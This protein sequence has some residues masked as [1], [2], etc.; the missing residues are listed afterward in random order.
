MEILILGIATAFNFI[1]IKWKYEKGRYGDCLLDLVTIIALSAMFG[2]T[3]T[4][5]SVAMIAS[6]IISLYLYKNPPKMFNH[7]NI[8]KTIKDKFN[9]IYYKRY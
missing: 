1:V 2:G 3:I 9:D 7:S 4:G 6:F 5:M 8:G